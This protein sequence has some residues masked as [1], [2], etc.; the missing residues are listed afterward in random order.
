MVLDVHISAS[1]YVTGSFFVNGR[2]SLVLFY[3]DRLLWGVKYFHL[4]G[5][6]SKYEILGTKKAP[7]G[8][9]MREA[10]RC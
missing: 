4:V 9:G 5:V 8:A 1:P 7:K 6:L 10:L 3:V 2:K